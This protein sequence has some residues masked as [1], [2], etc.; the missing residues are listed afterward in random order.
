MEK[1]RNNKNKAET[2]VLSR[3]LIERNGVKLLLKVLLLLRKLIIEYH[4][5]R[6]VSFEHPAALK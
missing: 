1:R 6:E 3:Y 5:M 2:S 4:L